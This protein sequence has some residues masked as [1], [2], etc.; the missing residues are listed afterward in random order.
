MRHSLDVGLV[1]ILLGGLILWTVFFF[2]FLRG[3]CL[4]KNDWLCSGVSLWIQFTTATWAIV[5]AVIYPSMTSDS[6]PYKYDSGLFWIVLLVSTSTVSVF[7]CSFIF[8][9]L[10]ILKDGVSQAK[11]LAK[12]LFIASF[13]KW[14]PDWLKDMLQDEHQT[15]EETDPADWWKKKQNPRDR[16]VDRF[17][18]DNL[19]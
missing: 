1:G 14:A 13:P 7:F 16:G 2:N 10:Q 11:E 8:V 3:I 17:G 4:E 12:K 6:S 9:M 19:N 18:K 5:M 15:A